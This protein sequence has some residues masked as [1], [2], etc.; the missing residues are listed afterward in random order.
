MLWVDQPV[1][2]GYSTG[3]RAPHTDETTIAKDFVGFFKNWS[4]LFGVESYKIFVAGESYAGRYVPYISSE[5]LDQKLPVSG[6]L[7]YDPCIGSFN[8]VQMQ[9]P[10]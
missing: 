4:K 1:G 8:Y 3:K 9:V 5:M 7:L 6:A 10:T 2:V